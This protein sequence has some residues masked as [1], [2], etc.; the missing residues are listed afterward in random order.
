MFDLRVVSDILYIRYTFGYLDCYADFPKLI[1]PFSLKVVIN[2]LYSLENN[3]QQNFDTPVKVRNS[4]CYVKRIALLY[5][6]T[7]GM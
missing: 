5:Q 2:G 1:L 6:S 7:L 4:C 3:V